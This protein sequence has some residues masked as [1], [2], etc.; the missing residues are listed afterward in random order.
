[1]LDPLV[2]RPVPPPVEVLDEE[3]PVGVPGEPAE[4]VVR[5]EPPRPLGPD[6]VPL[7][8]GREERPAVIVEHDEPDPD[9]AWKTRDR[10]LQGLRDGP[11]GRRLRDVRRELGGEGLPADPDPGGDVLDLPSQAARE[12][13]DIQRPVEDED[14]RFVGEPCLPGADRAELHP[15]ITGGGPRGG[16]PVER[17]DVKGEE[18]E[19]PRVNP[20]DELQGSRVDHGVRREGPLQ[21][22]R[23]ELRGLSHDPPADDEGGG[24]SG[25][26]SPRVRPGLVGGKGGQTLPTISQGRTAPPLDD[27]LARGLDP[28]LLD[29]RGSPRPPAGSLPLDREDVGSP[30]L[31]G[32]EIVEPTD[33]I[34][35]DCREL[36]ER[37]NLVVPPAI[38]P[39][40]ELLPPAIELAGLHPPP[41]VL[42]GLDDR[43]VAGVERL[44]IPPPPRRLAGRP[45]DVDLGLDPQGG[46]FQSVPE[47]LQVYRRHGRRRREGLEAGLVDDQDRPVVRRDDL[48]PDP[49]DPLV[50]RDL[51]AGGV[52][53]GDLTPVPTADMSEGILVGVRRRP[54]SFPAGGKI[55][56]G[57]EDPLRRKGFEVE[58]DRRELAG[59]FPGGEG[60][61]QASR[62]PDPEPERLRSLRGSGSLVSL[63]AEVVDLLVGERDTGRRVQLGIGGDVAG[64][65]DREP[66]QGVPPLPAVFVDR[67]RVHEGSIL[68]ED[69]LVDRGRLPG[70]GG[71]REDRDPPP[72]PVVVRP[73]SDRRPHPVAV[74][75]ELDFL[76]SV[77]DRLDRDVLVP[78]PLPGLNPVDR[79]EDPGDERVAEP[80]PGGARDWSAGEPPL[81]DPGPRIL[82]VVGGEGDPDPSTQSGRERL[83]GLPGS[84]DP[85]GPPLLAVR[86]PDDVAVRGDRPEDRFELVEERP[87]GRMPRMPD[88]VETERVDRGGVRH[89]LDD[90]DRTGRGE[91]A[92]RDE[93]QS[94]RRLG[95]P[96]VV[97]P[98]PV[99][100]PVD[101]EPDGDDVA[102]GGPLRIRPG[103]DPLGSRFPSDGQG[104][105]TPDVDPELL[106]EPLALCGGVGIREVPLRP[107]RPDSGPGEPGGVDR[108]DPGA[109]GLVGRAG[110]GEDVAGG[111]PRL[112]GDPVARLRGAR[113]SPANQDG[114][115]VGVAAPRP[116]ARGTRVRSRRADLPDPAPA[117]APL[118]E[119]G[120]RGARTP[121]TGLRICARTGDRPFGRPGSRPVGPPVSGLAGFRR[122]GVGVGVEPIYNA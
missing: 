11:E 36:P 95:L 91:P 48:R 112:H 61:S 12:R 17:V 97:V 117:A 2:R 31:A 90:E 77:E 51:P 59:L 58:V 28:P 66:D 38:L 22:V 39:L 30:V 34:P 108:V 119:N 6:V 52:G 92:S 67:E 69:E 64:F 81:P 46:S 33:E 109:D 65:E 20:A 82:R 53:P 57:P 3:P 16:V 85:D 4:D 21:G 110:P 60:T 13:G 106:G 62:R 83:G 26:T 37:L 15:T 5:D 29:L 47:E 100:I 18:I 98:L 41:A 79:P 80:R 116:A 56:P 101:P 93:D 96:V 99:V 55:A 54:G 118:D 102:G 105:E 8:V 84:V 68:R 114:P 71:S 107:R 120:L 7:G 115:V 49:A 103:S 42:V 104:G 70:A 122:F 1:M 74:L 19:P 40:L 86:D 89:P 50:S 111:R 14:V 45:L 44:P 78:G 9:E 113:R 23:E 24:N 94:R 121:E 75:V 10:P 43:E 73:V 63:G 76:P 87:S 25:G 72:D 35:G 27:P 32:G 88:G